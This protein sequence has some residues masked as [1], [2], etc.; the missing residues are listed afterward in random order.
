ML[1]YW[2]GLH[3]VTGI[4]SEVL[5]DLDVKEEPHTPEQWDPDSDTDDLPWREDWEVQELLEWILLEARVA[6]SPGE[7]HELQGFIE[8]LERRL[9]R[10]PETPSETLSI[11]VGSPEPPVEAIVERELEQ[12]VQSNPIS[13]LPTEL[14]H[15]IFES[16]CSPRSLA[17]FAPL[18]LSHVNYRFR[19]IVLDIPSLW[20]TIDDILPLPIVKLYLDRSLD[21]PLDI[22]IGSSGRPGIKYRKLAQLFQHLEPH[23]P[24][25][26]AL[27][28][29]TH[30]W[31]VI[32]HLDKL[33]E[34]SFPFG[35]PEKLEFGLCGSFRAD[36][37][38]LTF[39][40]N[41]P[42]SLQELHLWGY[43][44]NQ[45]I[46]TFPTALRRLQLN[47][48][49]ISSAILIAALE[50]S[51]GLSILVLEN[52]SLVGEPG[53]FTTAGSLVYLKFIRMVAENT[54]RFSR[55]IK[56]PA[57]ASLSVIQ[58]AS[59]ATTDFLATL[60]EASKEIRS[61]EICEYDLTGNDWLSIFRRAPNLTHLRVRASSSSD[62]DLH[63]LTTA[64]TLPNLTSITLDNE[65]RLTTL[66]VEQIARTHP[67]L[68]SIV[69]R[70]W[71]PSNVS[72][73]SL[74]TISKLVKNI[75]VE[76]FR[77][78]PEE[79]YDEETESESGDDD[80]IEGSWLSGD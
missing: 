51:P 37:R 36:D 30:D 3:A 8:R 13:L 74:A 73:D 78:S 53:T 27:K 68:E 47:D 24:R 48:V 70:G 59:P 54:V 69:L 46:D 45:W 15:K 38:E 41:E 50:R 26:K 56:T 11:D 29:V 77:R 18:I 20:S 16:V 76:T 49:W 33:M 42:D 6:G 52:C 65:L 35:G 5:S 12:Q 31:E 62:Q 61:V 39:T 32:E 1:P 19:S 25:V 40:L 23:A 9:G 75:F 72:A 79:D 4:L 34:R 67:K 55:F 44:F 22:T 43:R 64:Q 10:T 57:V 63:A 80:S 71:D 17:L 2:A 66:L 14:F 28:I 21:A 60:M 7:K 58:P